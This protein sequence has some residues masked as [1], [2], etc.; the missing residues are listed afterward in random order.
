M[1][2]VVS[3][4]GQNRTMSAK[5]DSEIAIAMMKNAG[6]NPLVPYPG[7]KKPW[8][9][10]HNECGENVSPTLSAIQRGGGCGYCSGRHLSKDAINE[11][12]A[13]ANLLP[14]SDYKNNNTPME[15]KCLVCGNTVHPI[16]ASV[17]TTGKGCKYC[18]KNYL[19]PDEIARRFRDANLKPLE[20]FVN[21]KTKIKC[22]CLL[23]GDIVSPI[24][25][26]IKNND[27]GCKKCANIQNSKRSL[28]NSNLEKY[29]KIISQ[30]GG[31][32]HATEYRGLKGTY[33][34][35][36]ENGH[37]WYSTLSGLGTTRW[38]EICA[39][40]NRSQKL[41]KPLPEIKTLFDN[42]SIE[43]LSEFKS[44]NS[45]VKGRCLRCGNEVN[46]I[47]SNLRRGQG[48]CKVCGSKIGGRKL[49][50]SDEDA[51]KKFFES[52]YEI[53]EG[54]VS[55]QIP[56]KSRCLTCGEISFPNLHNLTPG[57][58]TCKFCVP[59]APL[60]Q[61]AVEKIYSD[62]GFTLR[63]K[64]ERSGKPMQCVHI[65]CGND[66][67]ISHNALIS[68]NGC[69]FCNFGGFDFNSP[70]YLYIVHHEVF[71]SIKVGISGTG[72]KSNRLKDHKRHNWKL[73]EK[74]NFEKGDEAYEVEQSFFRFVR[75]E[76][77]IPVHLASEQM[78]QG[79]FTETI[80]GDEIS[81][82]EVK[83]LVQDTISAR[84]NF[85]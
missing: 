13:K 81:L 79:G 58:I 47:P 8:L 21:T 29:I 65:T 82:L 28:K 83:R 54:Y 25:N 50:I 44:V 33:F 43:M 3:S 32:L 31:K 1:S 73:Y 77:N 69:R 75:T 57:A 85:D 38:C 61:Q 67:K 66:I 5:I 74:F 24:L 48:G 84:I 20:E 12:F 26:Q 76:L 55:N 56:V 70:G 36:C 30:R 17:K 64:Y 22:E 35:E 62:L 78:P 71:D 68:G 19:S 11:V 46:V 40:K 63:D 10:T 72:S 7:I 27:R 2:I 9:C 49:R 60:S 16:Y 18:A 51:K 53:L 41:R 14:I 4:K 6:F 80:S 39:R 45:S 52:G 15:C 23:C 42:A 34:V 59:H 37:T